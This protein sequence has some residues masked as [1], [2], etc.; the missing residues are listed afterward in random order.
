MPRNYDFT[1]E[2]GGVCL[3]RVHDEDVAVVDQWHHRFSS[4]AQ[5]G[6]RRWVR[7][8][9]LRSCNHGFNWRVV[10]YRR[11]V[12]LSPWD[13]ATTSCKGIATNCGALEVLRPLPAL[14]I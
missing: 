9:I 2:F 5:A 7:A 8:P 1:V 14:A 4:H 10:K 3:R 6:C 13:A 11:G 12:P